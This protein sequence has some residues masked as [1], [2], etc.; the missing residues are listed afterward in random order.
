M[1][2]PELARPRSDVHLRNFTRPAKAGRRSRCGDSSSPFGGSLGE[3]DRLIVVEVG[4]QQLLI[5]IGGPD[6]KSFKAFLTL[7]EELV[8]TISFG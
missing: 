4:E 8:G 1:D 5:D 2:S 3:Y 7:A 6:A